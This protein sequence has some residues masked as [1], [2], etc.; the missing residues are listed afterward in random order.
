MSLADRKKTAMV[1]VSPVEYSS[2]MHEI[3][4]SL[5]NIYLL[6]QAILNDSA[7]DADLK[8]NLELICDAVACV[9]N[10]EAEFDIYRKTGSLPVQKEYFNILPMIRNITGE[11]KALCEEKKIEC[12]VEAHNFYIFS[13]KE[14][15]RR[16]LANIISNA[17]KYNKKDGRVRITVKQAHYADS[18]LTIIIEDTGIGMSA[19]TLEKIGT[20]F[21]RCRTDVAGS[22]LGVA[23]IKKICKLLRWEITFTSV[24]N[25]GTTVVLKVR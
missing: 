18:S 16:I 15:L 9:K 3:K 14:K 24:V 22:G 4:N 5:N 12:I 21:F 7:G 25:E 2:F 17:I 6:S 11:Y 8:S 19:A 20:P 13:D 23:Q 1:E 10:T